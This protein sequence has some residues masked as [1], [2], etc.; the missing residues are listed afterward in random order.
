MAGQG[1]NRQ[2]VGIDDAVGGYNSEVD[3]DYNPADFVIAASD[4]QG[5]SERIFCRVQPQHER[6]I[7]VITK[8]GKFPFK[9]NGDLI[10]WAVVRGIKVLDRLDPMPGFLGAAD[11][12]TEI[13]RQ[14]AYLQEFTTMFTTMERVMAVH[15]AAGAKGEARKL[16]QMI[17]GKVRAI[18]EPH[19]K[20]KCEKEV[21]QRFGHLLEGGGRGKL[22][23]SEEE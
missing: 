1:R 3:G 9:T 15:V 23:S 13:L 16:L 8:S 17:L 6:A 18:D 7:S 4:H 10:R 5:H 20:E 12:I 2:V 22:K 21:M 11:A 19:W 14:E